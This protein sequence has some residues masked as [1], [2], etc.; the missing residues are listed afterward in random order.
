MS[1]ILKYFKIEDF[2]T[3][4]EF[5]SITYGKY[6]MTKTLSID[7]ISA[8]EDRFLLEAYD[9]YDKVTSEIRRSKSIILDTKKI[10]GRNIHKLEIY[11]PFSQDNK[12]WIDPKRYYK[13]GKLP[14]GYD[15]NRIFNLLNN[16]VKYN[17]YNFKKLYLLR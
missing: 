3:K 12:D 16:L 13:K 8:T 1:K 11:T 17:Q 5:E 6:Y 14:I 7:M 4:I 15:K 9:L 10:T 2:K